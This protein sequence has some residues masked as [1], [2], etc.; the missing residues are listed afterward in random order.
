LIPFCCFF[1]L[2]SKI[3]KGMDYALA[4]HDSFG[5]WKKL[6]K[7]RMLSSIREYIIKAWRVCVCV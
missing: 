5:A 7:L 2:H 4:H 6:E 3:L 1:L